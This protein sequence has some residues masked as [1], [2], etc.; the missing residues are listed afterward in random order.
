MSAD[1]LGAES[2]AIL[3]SCTRETAPALVAWAFGVRVLGHAI[4]FYQLPPEPRRVSP[5]M[6][7]GSVGLGGRMYEATAAKA[8]VYSGDGAG[9]REVHAA[10]TWAQVCDL[11]TVARVGPDLHRRIVEAIDRR[12]ATRNPVPGLAHTDEERDAQAAADAALDAIEEL[13]ADLADEVWQ[14][15]RPTRVEAAVQLTLL[16]GLL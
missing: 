12:R 7:G 9:G 4:H 8:S 13:C 1:Q 11:V 14:A 16:D 5:T 3:E 10:V 15:C 6:C 2:T